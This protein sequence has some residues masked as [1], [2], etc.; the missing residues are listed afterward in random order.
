MENKIDINKKYRTRDGREVRLFTTSRASDKYT[1]VGEILE[2][3]HT[4]STIGIWTSE[5]K[6]T[7]NPID[8]WDTHP[9]DLVEV[10]RKIKLTGFLN[11]YRG[12]DIHS[13]H[14]TKDQADQEANMSLRT[15]CIDL[16]KYNIEFE[17]GEG[18]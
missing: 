3:G 15:A 8:E 13:L 11:V 18:L 16:S 14:S 1:V 4:G 5:G 6:Q 9:H 2:E 17:E 12:Y 10:K 7:D